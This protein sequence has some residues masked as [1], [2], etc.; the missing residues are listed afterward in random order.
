MIFKL[1]I[2]KK[3]FSL[4][5]KNFLKINYI[6]LTLIIIKFIKK[7]LINNIIKF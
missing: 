4:R 5:N 6:Y 7:N 2:K 3:I 1:K